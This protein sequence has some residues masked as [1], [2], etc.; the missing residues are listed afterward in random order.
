MTTSPD[1]REALMAFLGSLIE[2]LP[3]S[4]RAAVL[5]IAST[6][7]S[8]PATEDEA[9]V[10]PELLA[11]M[12]HL[13]DDY[14]RQRSCGPAA[15]GA[16]TAWPADSATTGQEPSPEILIPAGSAEPLDAA[17]MTGPITG[18]PAR[19]RSGPGRFR[20]ER[21]HGQGGLGRVSV[22]T[23]L[24]LDRRVALKELL[25]HRS[26]DPAS[27]ARF[28]LEAEVTGK[29]EHPGI[30]PVYGLGLAADG[31]PYY[32]TRFIRGES[33][34]VAVA[35]TRRLANNDP[36]G[37]GLRLRE[38]LLR[39]AALCDAISYAHSRGVLHRDLKPANVM[40]GPFGETLVI[41]W[42]HARLFEVAPAA[43]GEP[44]ADPEANTAALDDVLRLSATGSDA[45]E[46]TAQGTIVGT[47][48]YM[49]P[50]QAEGTTEG[51]GPA[52]DI[53]GLGAILHAIL[54]GAH[55]VDGRDAIDLLGKVR[56]GEVPPAR[57]VDPTVPRPLEAICRKAMALR[58]ADR[59]PS[60]RAPGPRRQALAGR[61]AGD[62]RSRALARAAGPP[63]PPPPD[64]RRRD[65]RRPAGGRG[66]LGG[67]RQSSAVAPR[68][69][70]PPPA[71]AHRTASP[72]P[73]APSAASTTRWPAT[74]C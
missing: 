49:S 73:A 26:D 23:D 57:A 28:V 53:Y 38:L 60:A 43:D 27:R 8:R 62:G 59:Y 16:S 42:S 68:S 31:R 33:L 35:R 10:P 22:A 25:D 41:D 40:L 13:L 66:R 51:L 72:S 39:F 61:R 18:G 74:P 37:A 17:P 36:A 34:A 11:V 14:F 67:D 30:V 32:A 7:R 12:D 19:P 48:A 1:D 4:E 70:R 6:S 45:Y 56:R 65:G 44:P 54:T 58:P 29:L 24:E 21:P 2:K 50:E 47:P 55:P 69:A 15:S 71:T 20:I 3:E 52:T 63:R 64:R 46:R 9:G 5:R